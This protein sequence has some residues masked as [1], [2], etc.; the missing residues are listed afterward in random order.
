M[1]WALFILAR[2][3]DNTTSLNIGGGQC[4]GRPPPQILRGPSPQSPQVSAPGLIRLNSFV[5]RRFNRVIANRYSLGDRRDDDDDDD[6]NA[7]DKDDNDDEEDDDDEDD[8]DDDDDDDDPAS[9]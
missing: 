6:D 1:F 2:A 5:T 4:M 8:D 7:D 9:C 3:S